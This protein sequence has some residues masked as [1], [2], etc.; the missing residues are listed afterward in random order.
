MRGSSPD[1]G[2]APEDGEEEDIHEV[3]RMPVTDK[4]LGLLKVPSEM[5]AYPSW[6]LQLL[7]EL[8]QYLPMDSEASFLFIEELDTLTFQQLDEAPLPSALRL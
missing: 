5:S 6:R 7:V 1:R 3:I 8:M 2:A 4:K